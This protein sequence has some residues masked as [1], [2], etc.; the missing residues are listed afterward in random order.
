MN[1]NCL[2]LDYAST[3]PTDPRVLDAMLPYFGQKFGNPASRTHDFGV[4]SKNAVQRARAQLADLIGAKK[5]EEIIFTSGAT[6]AINLAVKGVYENYRHKGNH[7]ITT[8]VEHKAVLDTCLYLETQGA[9]VTLLGVNQSGLINLEE[10][11]SAITPETVLISVQYVNNETGVIQPIS[12]IS[13]I[14]RQRDILFMTDATQAVGRIPLNV[15]K[16]NIDLLTFS[17]HKIYGPNGIGALYVKSTYPRIKITTQ[18][19]G[20]GHEFGL[21][22]GT[23][24]TPGIVGFGEAAAL[25]KESYHSELAHLFA[26]RNSIEAKL[27]S[28]P[29]CHINGINAPRAPHIVNFHFDGI[30]AEALIIHLRDNIAISN[31]SA[32]TSHKVEPSHVI[33]AMHHSED[34]AYCSLRLSIGRFTPHA[35]DDTVAKA[36]ELALTEI[37][38]F[39]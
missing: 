18:I 13:A 28:L 1:E 27:L 12:E 9:R 6:E 15:H 23:L 19:H 11:E 24:N 8:I 33:M 39:R 30:D 20:G 2:Y 10:L 25:C 36:F 32:C 21:R 26:L 14:A 29:D 16:E 3:T 22:S 34:T 4:E 38:N 35:A 5:D 7:I 17:A 31:G 37:A